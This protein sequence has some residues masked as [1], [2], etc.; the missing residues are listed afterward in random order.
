MSP[1]GYSD[2]IEP[3]T[4]SL[5]LSTVFT[6]NFDAFFELQAKD[7]PT[8]HLDSPQQVFDSAHDF[9]KDS[10]TPIRVL[11]FPHLGKYNTPAKR[12]KIIQRLAIRAIPQGRPA[13]ASVCYSS[14]NEVPL[15]EATRINLSLADFE[16]DE[17][18]IQVNCEG[19]AK[20]IRIDPELKSYVYEGHFEVRK[21]TPTAPAKPYLAVVNLID[22]EDYLKGVVPAEMPSTWHPEALKVQ[23]VA[24][25][26]YGLHQLNAMK[27]AR[28]KRFF[29]LDD[30]VQYQAFL[31]KSV[32]TATTT[33][34]V[35][36]TQSEI[37]TYQAQSGPKVATAFFSSDSGGHTENVSDIWPEN[38]QEAR[39]YCVGKKE[40]YPEGSVDSTWSVKKMASSLMAGLIKRGITT[41]GEHL[42]KISINPQTLP[43]GRT[44]LLDLTLSNDRKVQIPATT[45]SGILGLRNRWVTK[46]T[47]N[48]VA[49]SLLIDGRGFGHAVGMSQSGAHAMAKYLNLDY[50]SILKFYYTD[51][52][53]TRAN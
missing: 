25:R 49:D 23:A 33:A 46:V 51:V 29:D 10:A 48:A 22:F 9:G 2:S 27:T 6:P 32:Y 43:S 19:P 37:I 40:I 20:L 28:S 41:S 38:G 44:M 36:A 35:L 15:Q 13:T 16:A 50:A 47:V 24:A 12:E 5:E 39:S 14:R 21:I 26:S 52:E 42:K 8:E 31:G 45:L 1:P 17:T 30:T 53:L 4:D 11:I 7:I 3:P 18:P 34:A